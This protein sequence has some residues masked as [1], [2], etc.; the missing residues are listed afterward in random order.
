MWKDVSTF[1]ITNEGCISK[2]H[3]IFIHISEK[4]TY[5][6]IEKMGKWLETTSHK[7][8]IWMTDKHV[9]NP[10]DNQGNAAEMYDNGFSTTLP[11]ECL[12]LK[13]DNTWCW[14]GYGTLVTPTTS[15]ECKPVQLLEINN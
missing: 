3:E 11:S 6:P 8:D 15:S 10:T 1:E 12:K 7:E 2:R 9:C 13:R 5:N 14:W 4:K